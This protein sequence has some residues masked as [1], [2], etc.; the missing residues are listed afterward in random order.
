MV[1]HKE[2]AR[3]LERHEFE[4]LTPDQKDYVNK[5]YICDDLIRLYGLGKRTVELVKE[6]IGCSTTTA[7]KYMQEAQVLI[8]STSLYKKNYFK[9]FAADD[10]IRNINAI[11]G[12]I[13]KPN[14]DGTLSDELMSTE[15]VPFLITAKQ[16]LLK[17]LRETLG[18]DKEDETV[19][20]RVIPDMVILSPNV[21]DIGL[22]RIELTTKEII[23]RWGQR[24]N[25]G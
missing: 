24:V 20:E 5:V 3:K 23:E 4:N 13:Y 7:R 16:K 15:D 9:G 1:N 14:E 22:K 17:E 6:R 12:K 10:I 11:N 19:D 8:G 18:Y 25:M 2:I 21:E